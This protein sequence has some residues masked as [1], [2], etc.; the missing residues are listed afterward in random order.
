M[1][2]A[3]DQVLIDPMYSFTV[4]VQVY[5]PATTYVQGRPGWLLTEGAKLVEL[6]AAFDRYA[7]HLLQATPKEEGPDTVPVDQLV[8]GRGNALVLPPGAFEL[9]IIDCQGTLRGKAQLR[10]K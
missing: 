3:G 6:P 5:H 2:E 9:R 1:V 4:D 10:V 8:L 7:G